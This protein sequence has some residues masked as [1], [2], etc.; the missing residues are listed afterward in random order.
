MIERWKDVLFHSLYGSIA[1]EVGDFPTM[2]SLEEMTGVCATAKNRVSIR[3]D[4]A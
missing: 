3:K 4:G 2:L 1:A